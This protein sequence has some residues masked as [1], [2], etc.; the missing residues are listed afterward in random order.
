LII[1]AATEAIAMTRFHALPIADLRRETE[2]AVSIAFTVPPALA[3]DF[4]FTPGQYLTLRATIDGAEQRRSY[5]ICAG[6]DDGEL[7]VAIKNVPAGAFST[8]A[9]TTLRQGDIVDVMPPQGRFGLTPGNARVY[10]GIAAG[11][12]ITPI[13]SI[14]KSVLAREKESRFVLLY[15]SRATAAILFREQLEDLKDRYMGRLVVQHVL[16]REQQDVAAL[17][18]RI[19]GDRLRLLLPG[20]IATA[21]IDHAFI[22][23][24]DT[25]IDAATGALTGLGIAPE[26]IHSERFTS[27]TPPRANASAPAIA[28][29]RTAMIIHEG[30]STEV[31]MADGETVL[32]AAMRAG[33]D[34]PWSCRGG[35]C[36][37]C[38]ARVTEGQA[39]MAL[40]FSLETWETE[41]GYVLTCQARPLSAHIT[42]DYDHV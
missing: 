23:G 2:D 4:T 37:T 28:S 3:E 7:R 33:L 39:E 34:P 20:L 18:G 41:Q 24:P 9:N 27:T 29:D 31:P 21:A 6:L 14:L 11:S 25:M 19:D 1:S 32:D 40:N 22:C 10:L 26:R 42:V 17:N 13:M 8:M 16:S 15:G 30:R 35:M 38:R 5:S 36:S 12:G